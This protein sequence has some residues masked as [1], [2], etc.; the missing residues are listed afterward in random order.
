MIPRPF[1]QRCP[2]CGAERRG[3]DHLLG[4]HVLHRP[5]CRTYRERSYDRLEDLSHLQ[6]I[7]VARR[8]TA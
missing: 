2:D 4:P 6:A 5:G 7:E 8:A 3:P 1:P